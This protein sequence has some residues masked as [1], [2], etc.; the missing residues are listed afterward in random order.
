MKVLA[1]LV[2]MFSATSSLLYRSNV[3][4][5]TADNQ[6]EPHSKHRH[7]SSINTPNLSSSD[8]LPEEPAVTQL[9]P[10]PE[11]ESPPH[12]SRDTEIFPAPAHFPAPHVPNARDPS[13]T[14]HLVPPQPLEHPPQPLEHQPVPYLKDPV[15]RLKGR[16]LMK[17]NEET[18][19]RNNTN[20]VARSFCK[21]LI[22][23][24]RISC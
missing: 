7:H 3:Q 10:I 11:L 4:D 8:D 24:E 23:T 22:E 1:I 16:L 12:K 18:C 2:L 17:L 19:C 9:E 14:Q 20:K 15:K 21:I 5:T 13:V 6:S